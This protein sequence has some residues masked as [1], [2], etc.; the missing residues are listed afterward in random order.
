MPNANPRISAVI[1]QELASWLQQRSTQEGLSVSTLVRDIL[2]RHYEEVEERYWAR[3]GEARLASF[4]PATALS[5]EDA[6][7]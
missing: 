1:D 7:D 3:A 4:D 5:H 6:W 2:R